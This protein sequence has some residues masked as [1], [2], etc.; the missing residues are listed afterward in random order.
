MPQTLLSPDHTFAAGDA[1]K[2]SMTMK[3]GSAILTLLPFVACDCGDDLGNLAPAG[4]IEPVHFDFGPVTM[5]TECQA[6]LNVINTGQS[7]YSIDKAEVIDSNGDFSILITPKEVRKERENW[8][9]IAG[10]VAGTRESGTV[11]LT[12]TIPVD[13]G[14]LYATLTGIPSESLAALANIGCA[15]RDDETVEKPCS[16]LDFGAVTVD[17]SGAA[18]EDR[19]G[20]TMEVIVINEGTEALGIDLVAIN[21]GST[22]FGI[23]NYE[24]NGSTVTLSG[25][26]A[27][28]IPAGRAE[29]CSGL[30]EDGSNE[31][32]IK[33]KYSPTGLGADSDTL[34]ILTDAVEGAELTVP[35]L[36]YGAKQGIVFSPEYL[37]LN[38]SEGQTQEEAVLVSN[39]APLKLAST[40]LVSIWRRRYLRW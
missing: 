28:K 17:E 38:A 5:G 19:L 9:D 39:M 4:V 10:S 29:D 30:V 3:L 31:L 7:D 34:K 15:T 8:S 11:Q 13:N 24:Y 14:R 23:M 36:G 6:E 20:L 12:T 35:L 1:M 26:E 2:A 21:Q 22:E 25:E 37:N 16:E 32:T 40:P 33:A 18:I 27:F